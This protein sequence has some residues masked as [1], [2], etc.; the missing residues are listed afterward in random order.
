MVRLYGRSYDRNVTRYVG[1]MDQ[2][3]GVRLLELQQGAEKGVRAAH[4]TA[5]TG[6]AFLVLLD[7]G[8][9]ISSAEYRGAALGWRSQT[10]DIGPEYYEPLGREWLRG[11]F[12]GLLTTCGLTYAGAPCVD[13]GEELGLH[14]RISYTPAESVQTKAE[15]IEDDYIISIE[16]RIREARVFGPN[17]VLNR[18]IETKLGE[19]KIRIADSI[20]NEGWRKEPFMILYHINIG[21]PVVD[22]GSRL[23]STS[24]KYVPRD[25]EAWKGH[26]Q[27]DILQG[28]T[29][30][31]QEKVYLHDVKIDDD[32]FAYAG[33]VNENFNNG[34]GLG[35]AVA[36]RK[37]QLN[38]LTEWKMMGEGEYVVGIEPANCLVLG[39]DKERH[40]GTLQFLNPGEKRDICL[41]MEA[42]T[43]KD[44]ILSFEKKVNRVTG[45]GRPTLIKT[46]DDF[47]QKT[48]ASP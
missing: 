24:T 17:L 33:I 12:G 13:Q 35:V 11:F 20:T 36:F 14:G 9:D 16:G 40:W 38:R 46:V 7:R 32:G 28:P 27:F 42:L 19:N 31:F 47:V 34:D 6:F 48:K 23:V 4:V 15:W 8:M 18:R 2:I 41:E 10:G 5:G 25:E 44:E 21:F 39:R 30:G 1:K 43:N 26:E 45:G 22:D 29:E 3:G 37:S